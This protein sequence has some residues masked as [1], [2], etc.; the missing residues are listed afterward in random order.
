MLRSKENSV[1]ELTDT[2]PKKQ[3]ITFVFIY[4]IQRG[5]KTIRY[6]YPKKFYI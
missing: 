3:R 5:D 1:Y 2:Q 4:S 6:W